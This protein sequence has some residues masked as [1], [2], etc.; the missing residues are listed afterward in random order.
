MKHSLSLLLLAALLA[1]SCSKSG[2]NPE[3]PTKQEPT[4]LL[5]K[6]TNQTQ[7]TQ[8]YGKTIA[9]FTYNGKQLTKALFYNYSI[10]TIIETDNFNY[11]SQGQL[12][13]ANITYSNGNPTVTA[14]VTY[15]GSYASNVTFK[16]N[17]T[18]FAEN[19]LTYQ[20][21]KLVRW[22]NPRDVDM[23][24]T[25]DNVG[26]NI[27]QVANEYVNGTAN[28][29]AYTYEYLSFDDKHNLTD[30]LPNWVFFRVGN[31]E[32]GLGYILGANNP[33]NITELG[34]AKTFTYEYNSADYPTKISKS[35]NS[36]KAY[37]YEYITVQ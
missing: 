7:G 19:S 32:E 4:I 28:G 1:T 34:A 15:N 9:E 36:P 16:R 25:Y 12:T 27:K 20:N 23:I 13:G 8:D 33:V 22:F 29:K 31:G 18:A 5:T 3:E 14:T 2:S 35:G 11:N 24:Y 37:S 30:A 17:N 21:G 6:V 10:P 26:H